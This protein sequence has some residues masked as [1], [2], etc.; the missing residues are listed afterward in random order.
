[1]KL[2]IEIHSR[3]IKT[4]RKDTSDD[5]LQTSKEHIKEKENSEVQRIVVCDD[6]GE[7]RMTQRVLKETDEKTP[8]APFLKDRYANMS[9]SGNSDFSRDEGWEWEENDDPEDKDDDKF[10]YQTGG[11][12]NIS[13][14]ASELYSEEKG[15]GI[16][17]DVVV[18]E[19]VKEETKKRHLMTEEEI[20]EE[21]MKKNY[22]SN[23]SMGGGYE[24]VEEG[25]RRFK[26]FQQDMHA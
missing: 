19:L 16:I 2:V 13:L 12:K 1:V 23:F 20:K 14:D 11:E 10:W 9:N 8:P 6:D 7:L 15:P 24:D 18:P 4:D 17:N 5:E 3:L 21:F 26:E 22:S 25:E